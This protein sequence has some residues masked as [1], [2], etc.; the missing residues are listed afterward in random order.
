MEGVIFFPMVHTV[1][2]LLSTESVGMCMSTPLHMLQHASPAA[3]RKCPLFHFRLSVGLHIHFTLSVEHVGYRKETKRC[4]LPTKGVLFLVVSLAVNTISAL[5]TG[6]ETEGL[7]GENNLLISF[8]WKRS[9]SCFSVRPSARSSS[10]FGCSPW[11]DRGLWP[12]QGIRRSARQ[13]AFPGWRPQLKRR[14]K[15]RRRLQFT[16]RSALTGV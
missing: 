7:Y 9:K 3:S 2:V 5:R 8:P 4:Q 10:W 15:R 12:C 13:Q 11:R 1:T 14:V 16:L 6:A